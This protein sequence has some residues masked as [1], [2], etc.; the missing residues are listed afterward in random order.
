MP[1]SYPRFRS[2]LERSNP[3]LASPTFLMRCLITGIAGFAGRHLAA[4]LARAATMC[5]AR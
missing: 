4:L 2:N 3:D 5:T 1:H